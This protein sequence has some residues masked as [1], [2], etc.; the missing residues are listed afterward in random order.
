MAKE[1]MKGPT[2][3]TKTNTL[4]KRFS[5]FPLLHAGNGCRVVQ[6]FPPLVKMWMRPWMPLKKTIYQYYLEL[7]GRIQRGL[8]TPL[9]SSPAYRKPSLYQTTIDK[10]LIKPYMTPKPV[11]RL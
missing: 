3:K 8:K 9:D 7:A 6:N 4:L 1:S 10:L 5:M 11:Y 2:L